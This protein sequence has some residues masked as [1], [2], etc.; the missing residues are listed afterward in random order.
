MKKVGI[1]TLHGIHNYGSF[2]QAYGT[3]VAV[4]RC[5]YKA[6]IINY[7]YPNKFH[8][9]EKTLKSKLLHVVNVVFK[10]IFLLGKNYKLNKNYND[11]FKQFYHLSK[12]YS[13]HDAIYNNPPHYD[14]YL[15]GSDQIWRYTFSKGDGVFFMDFAPQGS[16]IISFSSSFGRIFLNDFYKEKYAKW[17][18]RFQHLSVREPSGIDIIASLTGQKATCTIDPSFILTKEEWSNIAVKPKTKNKYIFIY[19]FGGEYIENIAKKI[20][21]MT[22]YDIIRTNGNFLDYFRKDIHYILDAGPKEWLGYIQNAEMVFAGSF[23][24]TALSITFNRPFIAVLNEEENHNFRQLNILELLNLD[25]NKI[26]IGQENI[27]INSIMNI[28][29]NINW[30]QVNTLLE[31]NRSLAMHYL[32]NALDN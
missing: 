6:E 8:N 18:L 16:K 22:G 29:Q 1:I 9:Q 32:K 21:A 14:I 30:E 24:G 11:C 5:G 27:N 17:L 13:T 31:E 4:E 12:S 25:T 28:M 23:H 2:M 26:K 3:Q 20:Q 15:T 19:G 7:R 10:D